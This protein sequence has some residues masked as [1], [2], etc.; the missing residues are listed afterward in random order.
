M[1]KVLAMVLA[2]AMAFALT[3][4]GGSGMS[5]QGTSGSGAGSTGEVKEMDMFWFSDGGDTAAMQKLIDQYQTE[6][7][8]IKINLIEIPFED[9][10]NKIMVS[11]SGGTPPALAR[12][13]E[14]VTSFI[15]EATIDFADYVDKDELLSQFLPSIHNYFVLNDK[16]CSVPTDVTA[17]G[18]I[19][20]KTAFEK[21]G[22]SVPTSPDDIWTWEEFEQ[23]LKTVMEKGGVQYGLVI[24]NP[25]H[26][27]STILYEFGGSLA[28]ENGGNLS[29]P[30]SLAAIEYTKHLFDEGIV[31]K[32]TWL[33]GEDPNNMFRSGQVAAHL[34]GNWIFI[35]YR[36]NI[37]DFEW[38]VTYLPTE[39]TRS[40]VP[41]GKQLTA[42]EGSGMEQEAVDFIMWVTAQ[43]QNAQYCEESLLISPRL[44]NAELNYS[45]GSEY[46]A[47]MANELDNTVP[48]ASFDW[49]YPNLS[50]ELQTILEEGFSEVINGTM[51]A[52]ELAA[53]ADAAT[54]A[55]MGKD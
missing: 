29:S 49:G 9:I 24:D 2:L 10:Q 44:D 34:S 36:D 31:P 1:K 26:R 23:A 39:V 35:N 20:N 46:F 25:T 38:G 17:N 4:C 22:V 18:L 43:E 41:G 45:F 3:A 13:T 33:G 5:D 30:E 37:T 19:Y 52:Q 21:A 8:N 28:N 15:N 53:E 6:N 16:V 14:S 32:S 27:W 51:T 40:S 54:N 42:F 12:T 11:V 50:A 55:L 48:E 47:I 7:P